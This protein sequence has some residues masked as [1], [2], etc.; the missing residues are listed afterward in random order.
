MYQRKKYPAHRAAYL[1]FVG[2]VPDDL[3]VC[4]RCDVRPCVNP[5]HLFL[6][7]QS[8]NLRDMVNKGR[9]NC[10]RGERHAHAKLTDNAAA[11]ILRLNLPHAEI[12]AHYG[13][14][15]RTVSSIKTRVTWKH[16]G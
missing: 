4:H 7:T 15:K 11:E 6:G 14:S 10:R 9:G 13:I 2:P 5:S 1:L 12:A 3:F 16:I 8:D